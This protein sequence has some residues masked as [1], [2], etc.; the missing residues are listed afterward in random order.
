MRAG[1]WKSLK[2][3]AFGAIIT[4]L[5]GGTLYFAANAYVIAH[6]E[7][8]I[9]Y[10]LLSHKGVHHYVQRVVHPALYELK[11]IGELD[12]SFY[13]PE[14]LSSSFMV[15]NIH[16]YF[17][18]ELTGAGHPKIYYKLAA[19]NPRNPVNQAD[20]FE[21]DLIAR[22]NADR[23]QKSYREVQVINGKKYLYHAQPFLENNPACLKCHGD[24]QD[25]PT[26]L[27]ARY[28]C[29]GGFNEK[30][31]YIRAIE[32]I[33]APVQNEFT[34]ANIVLVAVMC[35]FTAL[36]TL[37][38]LNNRLK[39][40]LQ[41]RAEDLRISEE[42]YKLLFDSIHD[43]V[44]L[45]R[46]GDNGTPDRFLEVNETACRRLGYGK[47]ELLKLSPRDIDAEPDSDRAVVRARK[48]IAAGAL[49]FETI[50]VAKDGRRIPVESNIRLF[51]KNGE[52]YA[53][54]IARDISDRKRADEEKATMV[55][56]LQQVQKMES[57]GAL[58]GGIAHD[59]NNILSPILGFTELVLD[60]L[61]PDSDLRAPLK[62]VLDGTL[63][64]RDL[65]KQILVFSRQAESEPKPI[66]LQSVLEEALKLIRA[67]LPA[68]IA[69][70]A[71]I[72][73]EAGVVLA[74]P[75][76]IH[77]IVM[78]LCTNAGHAMEAAGGPLSVRLDA[79]DRGLGDSREPPLEPGRYARITIADTGTGI[80]PQ[81]LGR[82]FEPY[83]TT[84]A[85]G[86]GTGLGL[87]VVHG[88]V[89]SHNGHISVDSTPGRGTTFEIYFPVITFN[90]DEADPEDCGAA[91]S[92]DERILLVDDDPTIV[93]LGTQSLGKLGYRVTGRVS[94][95]EALAAFKD[96]PHDY[97]LIITDLTMP[98]MTGDELA[99]RAIDLRR[100][101]PVI[102]CSG[103]SEK[104]SEEK[105]R[106]IGIKGFLMKPIVKS[107]IGC[108]VRRVLDAAKESV[109]ET[110]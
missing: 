45:H 41:S 12:D 49:S 2:A 35:G 87:A 76:Q 107:E 11:D 9:E 89:K 13:E 70:T 101:I 28:S 25:A 59:F 65:V 98:G 81:L 80:D 33:R 69:I 67:S 26:Q 79:V 6:A 91:A 16:Q 95:L 64:A 110:I 97:D 42:Q 74:D 88:I 96:A 46:I 58:A 50:H 54:S 36:M 4:A 21:Q 100:D 82:I 18:E 78:N 10:L 24:P 31:G 61:P 30:V 104:L 19:T 15:R 55:R 99:R 72:E 92:G 8:D 63:R 102:I 73:G 53:L 84:K 43:A 93:A 39:T 68:T 108:M 1:L 38:F 27:R 22:F 106:A 66:K 105:A 7:R 37:T 109:K 103:F 51:E 29:G 86:K 34:L 60:D 14:F 5:A 77:Q 20:A 3:L 83:F 85:E 44:F 71:D 32:S 17:N 62:Q 23:Q 48:L 94:S 52:K 56:Q 75:T 47:D 40:R 90:A 57:L